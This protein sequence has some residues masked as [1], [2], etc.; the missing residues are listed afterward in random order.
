MASET[1]RF[2]LPPLYPISDRRLAGGL[3]HPRIA[4]LVAAGGGA[5]IQ[6]REKEMAD[7]ELLAELRACVAP[8]DLAVIVNDRPDLALLAGAAGVHLGQG[9]LDPAEARRLLGEGAVIGVSSHSVEEALA[10]EAPGIDYVALGPVFDSPTKRPGRPPLGEEAVAEAARRLTLPLV[11]IGGITLERAP[12]L[13]AAGAASVAV[14]SDIMGAP[15]IDARVREWIGA[16]A[17]AGSGGPRDA[18]LI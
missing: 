3:G 14:I 16:A 10:A 1:C 4:R 11:A 15:A 13:W 18:G 8:G 7:G 9:D 2:T 5:L 17:R 6:I 12:A